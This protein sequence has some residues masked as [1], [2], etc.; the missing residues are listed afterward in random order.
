MPAKSVPAKYY[1]AKYMLQKYEF[2]ILFL[3]PSK[4]GVKGDF[5]TDRNFRIF[6]VKIL[7]PM[8]NE[9]SSAVKS[10]LRY[11]ILSVVNPKIRQTRNFVT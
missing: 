10:Y 8:K 1:P 4:N 2:Y 5:M 7:A 3:Y 9:K 6:L 11:T